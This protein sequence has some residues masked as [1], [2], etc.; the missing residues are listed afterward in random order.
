MREVEKLI[1]GPEPVARPQTRYRVVGPVQVNGMDCW[2]VFSIGS[3][4][5][6]DKQLTPWTPSFHQVERDAI[7]FANGKRIL[8][9]GGTKMEC[10]PVG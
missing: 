4:G 10:K 1:G 8:F 7:D 2:A 9:F 5:V 6:T 3:G